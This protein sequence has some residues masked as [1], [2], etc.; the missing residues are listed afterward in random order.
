MPWRCAPG[1]VAAALL[2][3]LFEPAAVAQERLGWSEPARLMNVAHEFQTRV[4]DRVFFSEGSAA[5]GAKARAALGAQASWLLANPTVSI[6]VEGHADDPGSGS[7][8]FQ[9]SFQRASAVR[10]RL[11][12]M[13]VSPERV[14]QVAYGKERMIAACQGPP[15]AA[16]NRRVVTVVDRPLA[17]AAE[18]W[19][20]DQPRRR[21]RRLY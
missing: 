2:T 20:G 5:L 19:S 8:N 1:L 7:D 17:N 16:Q 9:I 11:V 12:E 21:P 15:C 6:T 10:G 3:M 4:G 14:R 13:G 18:K